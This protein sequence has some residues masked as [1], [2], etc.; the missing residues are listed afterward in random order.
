MG[1]FSSGS[2]RI[3]EGGEEVFTSYAKYEI[4]DA[5]LYERA[6]IRFDPAMKAFYTRLKTK[7]KPSKVALV[8]VMRKMI[9]ILN[10]RLREPNATV[11]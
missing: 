8:A 5:E 11:H 7:G 9:I 2:K 10:A 6:A 1:S 4:G 3:K